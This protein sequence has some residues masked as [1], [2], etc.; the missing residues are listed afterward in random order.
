M[1]PDARRPQSVYSHLSV[2]V[3]VCGR[4]SFRIYRPTRIRK[5]RANE[6][7]LALLVVRT[8]MKLGAESRSRIKRASKRARKRE[9]KR[10]AERREEGG[11]R[12]GG[13]SYHRCDINFRGFS[14]SV[15]SCGLPRD[16]AITLSVR[17][18]SV[19]FSSFF[20]FFRPVEFNC[21]SR[22]FRAKFK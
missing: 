9:K 20:S 10:E 7:T 18:W 2:R 3:S 6:R 8:E 12:K 1:A 4:D 15:V 17:E 11:G 19:F 22:Y 13:R 14:L 16:L 5:E 21:R